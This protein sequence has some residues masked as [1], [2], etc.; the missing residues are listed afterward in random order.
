M[1]IKVCGINSQENLDNISKLD[2]DMVGFNFYIKSKRHLKQTL[3]ISE[4]KIKRVGV[5]VQET[6]EN[7][8]ALKNSHNLDFLQLHGDEDLQLCT[9]LASIAPIIKVFRIGNDFDFNRIEQFE[10]CSK[11]FLFDTFT[12]DYG[13]SGNKFDWSIL[14]A[15][16]LNTPFLLSGG[17][18]PSDAADIAAIHHPQFAGIDLNSK[19]E[20]KPGIKD[21]AKLKKFTNEIHS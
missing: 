5:F 16:T 7:I 20:I 3:N 4:D 13:G 17:I 1:I 18:S 14:D 2:I 9:K 12:R 21:I 11:Y 19:F 10:N 15:Y 8:L 6:P